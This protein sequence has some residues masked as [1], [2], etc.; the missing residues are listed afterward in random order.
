MFSFGSGVNKDRGI[1][2]S[3]LRARNERE[4]KNE[5]GGKGKGKEGNFS[6]LPHPLPALLLAP[7]SARSLTLVLV[8]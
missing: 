7:F 5:R 6:F 3:V 8:L 1:G 2:F 4:P